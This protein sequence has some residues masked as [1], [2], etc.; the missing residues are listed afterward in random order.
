[1]W[2]NDKLPFLQALL[3][4]KHLIHSFWSIFSVIFICIGHLNSHN[5]HPIHLLSVFS[6]KNGFIENI[7]KNAP[8]GQK[9]LQNVIGIKKEAII[10]IINIIKEIKND[11]LSTNDIYIKYQIT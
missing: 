7:D 8:N 5:L 10:K 9:Y 1:M 3:H 2:E 4:S 11:I 6:W